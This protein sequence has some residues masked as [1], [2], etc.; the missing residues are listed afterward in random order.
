MKKML[1]L[2]GICSLLLTISCNHIREPERLSLD[3]GW[4]FR[5]GD[6]PAWAQPGFDDSSWGTIDP[7]KI[8][9]EQGFKGYNGFAWYRLRTVI[10]SSLKDYSNERDSL[11]I[12]L[13]RIDDCD[14]VFL[15]GEMIGENARTIYGKTRPDDGFTGE[16][17][18]WNM[19]RHYILAAS[20]PRIQWDKE[21]V[22]AVRCF[23]QGGDGGMFGKPFEISMRGL[24]EKLKFDFASTAFMF[25]GDTLV[26]KDFSVTNLTGTERLKGELIIDARQIDNGIGLYSE[27]SI[28]D[29][30][31]HL[32]INRSVAVRKNIVSPAILHICFR[33][34]LSGQ[35]VSEVLEI[36][37]ILTP[38]PPAVP[39]ING[40]KVFGV[41][42]WSPFLFK[43]AATGLPPLKYSASE[44]PEG[45]MINAENG[46]IT[47]SMK[48]K[49]EYIVKLTVENSVGYAER[50]LKIV[51]GDLISLT[52]P[53][54][55]NSWNCWGLSVSDRKVRQS[56]GAMKAS[57][58]IDHGWSYIN[59]DDG[60][61]DTHDK[62]GNILPNSKFPNMPALC[63]YVHSLGLKTGIYS[64]PGSKTCGGYEGSYGFE[65]RD[66]M[67]Y[68]A[69]GIDYL[70]YD[71]CSY[72]N[73]A[74]DPTPEQL[75][76]PYGEMKHALRKANR[77]IH[78]SLCQ[79]GMGD[80][81]TWGAEVDGNSWRTTGDITD[82]WESLSSIGFN[83]G[84]CSPWSGPG[85]WN[86]PDMLVVG[87]VG[88]GSQ[89]HYTRLTPNE[90]YTHLTL[91]SLLAAPL[92]L[93]CDL[94]RLDDFTLNLLT[95]DEVLDVN[96]DPL[97]KQAV[98]IRYND[99][100]EIW[101]REQAD[102]SRAVGL[103]NKTDK[104]VYVP[105]DMKDLHLEGKWSIRDLWTQTDL[106][107]ITW[108]FEMRVLPHGA[109]LIRLAPVK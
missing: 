36:P 86:D 27:R 5:T 54:G 14:Q 91:W 6:D 88:W 18:R 47:G 69:W 8:W 105:V 100:Y 7:K 80:V 63:S 70:K 42:P 21:N 67:T 71:W 90:Q 57:G 53:L 60:W 102:S 79:Y 45:L 32:T 97:G 78:Y 22:I 13:G 31:P 104:P 24:R 72:G 50:D 4:K 17:G 62:Y 3:T 96:Q 9:E 49:G 84:K 109:R 58:L 26:I 65:A 20:D 92:L 33:E 75:K 34:A 59:I 61:E 37:Y 40:P 108:H 25:S 19:E 73:I 93:G 38:K 51:V 98:R 29:L 106:G 28:V 41:R 94:S 39:R 52:P 16:R 11:Q 35:T 56:A 87:W 44:L 2:S 48:K 12:I 64:S 66:A 15:N 82:T 103:F 99:E 74:P 95:N 89:L 10:W 1:V 55:W 68:A 85:R 83:Q 76:K 107:K 23:D 101:A 43:V 46:H 30:T 81:W 77:D